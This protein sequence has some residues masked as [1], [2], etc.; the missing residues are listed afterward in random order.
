MQVATG[1]VPTECVLQ[2][3]KSLELYLV[4]DRG[5]PR[6]VAGLF[7][8]GCLEAR[9]INSIIPKKVTL[10]N[11]LSKDVEV[12]VSGLPLNRAFACTTSRC[13]RCKTSSKAM[14]CVLL[15][16]D[17]SLFERSFHD[18]CHSLVVHSRRS[19][20]PSE[21]PLPAVP[22]IATTSSFLMCRHYV[23]S[24]IRDRA[25]LPDYS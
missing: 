5:I 15:R 22:S 11:V 20:L 19:R 1:R 6:F 17:P 7:M 4:G 9:L 24:K 16:V 14:A 25:S 13:L 8:E 23:H 2:S 21:Q 10:P 12:P 3:E 18:V